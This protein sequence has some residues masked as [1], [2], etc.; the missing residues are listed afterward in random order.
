MR[1]TLNLSTL[2]LVLTFT[3]AA[4]ATTWFVNPGGGGDA[5][6]IQGGIDLA[7]SGDV[8]V[9][10]SGTY[11]GAGNVNVSFSGKDITVTSA[12]GAHFTIIDCQNSARGFVIENGEG[13]GAVLEGFTI[14]NG[15]ASEGGAIYCDNTSPMIRFNVLA[16]N[17]AT[18]S[19]GALYVN[20][21][22]P[23]IQNNTLDSNGAPNGGGVWI[24]GPSSPQLYTNIVSNSTSGGA[25]GCAGSVNAFVV[26]ND[27]Y[28]NAGGFGDIICAGNHGGNF[29]ADPRFCGI[30]GSGN[31]YVQQ[32]SPCSPAFSPCLSAVGALGVN[33]SVTATEAATWGSIKSLYR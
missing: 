3:S 12:A 25:F 23:T 18:V 6:T 11:S 9:V 17:S 24:Q 26:C 27:T 20:G 2:L 21:G 10:A 8:V 16:N 13:P 33:C 15:S 30:P 28:G 19:G 29:S 32:I 1:H 5:T 22:A 7:S 14:K 4:H 31:Y